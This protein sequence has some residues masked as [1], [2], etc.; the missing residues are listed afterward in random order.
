MSPLLKNSSSSSC[1]LHASMWSHACPF[2]FFFFSSRLP[3]CHFPFSPKKLSQRWLCFGNFL[4]T[5]YDLANRLDDPTEAETTTAEPGLSLFFLLFGDL[6]PVI[7]YFFNL[8]LHENLGKR[9]TFLRPLGCLSC[10]L[11]FG[12]P[13]ILTNRSRLIMSHDHSLLLPAYPKTLSILTCPT[14]Q[15]VLRENFI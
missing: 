1:E 5:N 7:Y 13:R 14:K 3:S 11:G 2:S 10:F 15:A 4:A 9:K 8:L 6:V 12:L